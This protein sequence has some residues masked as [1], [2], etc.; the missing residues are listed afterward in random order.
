MRKLILQNYQSPGDILMLTAA[1]RDL[2]RSFPNPFITDVRTPCPHLWEHNPYL[3]RLDSADPEALEIECHYPSIHTSN[4]RPRYFLEAFS[5]FIGEQLN[6]TIR[7]TDFAGTYTSA[8][9]RSV[10]L[11]RFRNLREKRFPS[12]LS[13]LGVSS[14]TRSSGGVLIGSSKS[15]TTFG[16]RSYLFKWERSATITL[17]YPELSTYEEKQPSGKLI[18]LVHHADGVLTPVSLAMHL[19][20]AVPVRKGKAKNRP[21][22]VVAGSFE[23]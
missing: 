14:T 8:R 15:F 17:G 3:T 12:G 19:A 7:C 18:R 5:D 10:G 22:V 9:P 13:L 11:I 20:A 1:V 2:H 23:V 4:L 6:L 21:C 16:K